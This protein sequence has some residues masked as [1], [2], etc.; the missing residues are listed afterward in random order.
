MNESDSYKF[1][2]LHKKAKPTYCFAS[3]SCDT[4][5]ASV[6]CKPLSAL[7]SRNNSAPRVGFRRW[8]FIQ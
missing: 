3:Q 7:T 1:E 2:I 8:D 5:Y 6:A 4:G